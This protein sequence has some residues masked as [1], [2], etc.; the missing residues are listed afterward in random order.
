MLRDGTFSAGAFTSICQDKEGFLWFGTNNG[1]ARYDGYRL[2]YFTP[3]TAGQ[4]SLVP[5]SVFPVTL[6][7]SGDLWVG[8]NGRG[9]FK[10]LRDSLKFVQYRPDPLVPKSSGEDIVLAVQEDREGNLWVGTRTHGLDKLDVN[11]KAFSRVPLAPSAEVIWDVLV[12][13]RGDIWAGTLDAGL[14]RIEAATGA[15]INYRFDPDDP[16]SLGGNTVWTVFEDRQGAIWVG[17]KGGGLNRY[18]PEKDRFGRIFGSGDFLRDL[19]RQTIVAIAE[20]D[21]GRLWLGTSTDGLRMWD[22]TTDEYV[23]YRHDPQDPESLSDNNITSVFRD[24]SGV[25]WVGTIRGGLNKCST[26]KAKFPH[27]KRNPADPRS[28]A[29]SDVRTL[30]PDGVGS[31]WIGTGAGLDRLDLRSGHVTHHNGRPAGGQGSRDAEVLVVRGDSRGRIWVGTESG[32]LGSLDPDSGI[33]T[34]FRH[35]PGDANSLSDNRVQALWLDAARP[36]ILWVGT[37][38]GL[39]RFEIR[40]GRWTRFFNDPKDAASLSNSII[41]AISEDG[42]GFLWVGTRWGLNKLNKQTGRCERYVHH[43][44]D[45]PGTSINDNIIHCLL[46]GRGGSIWIGTDSGLNR[47]DAANGGWRYL[48]QRDGLS[49]DVV[50]GLLQEASGSI[51]VSTNR[52]LSRLEPETGK[53]TNFGT[54]DGLQG[55]AF[56]PG[57]CFKGADGR[58]YFGG[59]NGLNIIDPA[60]IREDPF[61]PPVVWMAYR[62]GDKDVKLPQPL[63]A[64]PYL[65]LPHNAPLPVLEFAALSFAAPEL[66]V[67]AYRLEPRDSEWGFLGTYNKVS[68]SGIGAGRYTLRVKAANSDGVWN[69]TGIGIRIRVRPPFWR[70]WWFLMIAG[71][72]LVSGAVSVAALWR[73]IRSLSLAAGESLESAVEFY[74]LTSRE[75]EILQLVILGAN[76]KDIG[77]KLFISGSTV[78]NHIY[79]IYQKLGV[80]NRI[81]LINRVAADAHKKA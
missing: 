21:A 17:T 70:A 10:F 33:Y 77:K 28:L 45:I 4:S 46:E 19:S 12:D 2:T 30:W 37:H 34:P 54:R 16:E 67:F 11:A 59:A 20:D 60:G 38:G 61:V 56:N 66:N 29:H 50:C 42:Q 74:E 78:R 27:Y 9:L 75:R 55:D 72:F 36:D 13:S 80:R 1:L 69:E 26:G 63:A 79:N 18:N 68:L 73:K 71:T 5:V 81:E 32:G 58:L 48:T 39:N 65:T 43:L 3:N 7:R 24:A 44:G 52:G 6:A 41:T 62:Q 53:I 49:G 40:T 47:L 76:N 22:R 15:V 25:L 51:W 64:L 31:V 57:A 8:T 14:F 35:D 23:A